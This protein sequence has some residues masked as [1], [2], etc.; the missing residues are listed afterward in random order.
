MRNP[1][2]VDIFLE[3]PNKRL[4]DK[5]MTKFWHCWSLEPSKAVFRKRGSM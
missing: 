1:T 4:E 5:S 3:I 2:D